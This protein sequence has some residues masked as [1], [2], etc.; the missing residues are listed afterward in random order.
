MLNGFF[1]KPLILVPDLHDLEHEFAS[2]L[3][4][5]TS[6]LILKIFLKIL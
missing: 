6:S 2:F 1:I 4:S 3:S 5:D